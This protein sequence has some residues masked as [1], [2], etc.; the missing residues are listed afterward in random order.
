MFM[1]LTRYMQKTVK[2]QRNTIYTTIFSHDPTQAI[3][4]FAKEVSLLKDMGYSFIKKVLDGE[5]SNKIC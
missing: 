1:E 4:Y 3:G 2:K 5:Q